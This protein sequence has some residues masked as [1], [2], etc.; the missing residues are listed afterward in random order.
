MFGRLRTIRLKKSPFKRKHHHVH[1]EEIVK[2]R[3]FFLSLWKKRPHYCIVCGAYLGTEPHSYNFHHIIGKRFQSEY[4][5]DITYNEKNIIL[6]CLDCHSS[7]ENGFLPP[8][9]QKLKTE[10]LRIYSAFRK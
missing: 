7:I 10:L 5:I 1:T 2:L 4:S 3:D 9:L 8:S 6:V